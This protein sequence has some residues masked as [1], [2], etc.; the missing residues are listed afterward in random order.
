[1]HGLS[2]VLYRIQQRILQLEYEHQTSGFVEGCS[3]ALAPPGPIIFVLFRP[4]GFLNVMIVISSFSF[5]AE[6]LMML[7]GRHTS[8]RSLEELIN[9]KEYE[10]S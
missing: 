8:K 9:E 3:R 10:N 4:F 7:Y 6:F 5:I 2:I 1:M